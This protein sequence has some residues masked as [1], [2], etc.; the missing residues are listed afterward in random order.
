MEFPLVTTHWLAEHLYLENLVILDASMGKVVGKQPIVYDQPIYIPKSQ[1]LDLE[2]TFCD[3]ASDQI[4]AFPTVQQF[5]SAAQALGINADSLVV[6]YDNQGVYSSPRAWCI[7]QA[8][9]FGNVFVLD[10]GLPQWL[11]ESRDTVSTLA[12]ETKHF[13]N[14]EGE[15][16]PGRICD[17]PYILERLDRDQITV[18]DARSQDRFLGQV[19][20]PR[21]GVRSG[22]IPGALNLP[23]TEV[24]DGHGLKSPA[25]LTQIFD[26]LLVSHPNQLIFSCGSGITACIVL[27]AA[28]I[29]GYKDIVLYDGSW[30]DWGS[31]PSLPIE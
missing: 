10:G 25:Q 21:A 23:F 13:G 12:P 31:H 4:H 22:H 2:T 27:L 29:A 18:L 8:M 17:S 5:T 19:P 26:R 7:F 3:L 6:I 11:A 9:G 30:S 1:R 24:L 16:L 20:E 14:I 15:A 28:V